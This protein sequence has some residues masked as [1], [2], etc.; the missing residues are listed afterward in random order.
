MTGEVSERGNLR[1]T[2]P[3]VS[4]TL[5]D[6]RKEVKRSWRIGKWHNDPYAMTWYACTNTGLTVSIRYQEDTPK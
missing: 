5:T 2:F 3:V 1:F 4:D 6:A